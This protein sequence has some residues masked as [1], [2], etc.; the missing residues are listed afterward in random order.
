MREIK[1]VI[2][3]KLKTNRSLSSPEIRLT[4]FPMLATTMCFKGERGSIEN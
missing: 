1:S 4:N 2:E 3:N